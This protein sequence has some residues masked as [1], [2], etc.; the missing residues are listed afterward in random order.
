MD[1]QDRDDWRKFREGDSDGLQR[2][3]HRHK[4]RLFSYCFYVTGDRE[5][6]ED[7]VQESFYK[8][9]RQS[10]RLDDH[11]SIK[12]WLFIC[13]RNLT[14]NHLKRHRRQT[15]LSTNIDH[16]TSEL[17]VETR[18]FIQNVLSRLDRSDRELI[19]LREYQC[20][21]INTIAKLLSISEEAV[22]VRLYRVRKQMQQLA[23]G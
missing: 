5:L 7:V 23:K 3:Y 11:A 13:T 22:R 4:D 1:Q 18:L 2:I 19:L 10:Q 16:S 15:L 20:Y 17:D 12:D 14:F 8:L 6:S 21:S 9:A